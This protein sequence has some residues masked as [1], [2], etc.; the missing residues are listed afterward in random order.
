MLAVYLA[1][2]RGQIEAYDTQA[3]ISVTKNLIDHGSLTVGGGGWPL[4]TP[5][6]PYGIGI[7]VLAIPAYLVSK[8]TGHFPILVSVVAPLLTALCVVLVFRI[9]RCLRW[10][11]S[12][13]VFA[14]VAFGILSMAV[15]YTTELF[16]EPAVTLCVL[17]IILGL[18]RWN[19]GQRWAPLWIGIA[20]AAAVQF[21]SDSIVTVWILL[22]AT[23]LFVP[24]SEI[25]SRRSVPLVL[26]PMALSLVL[27]GSYNE[28]RYKK[29]FIDSYGPGGGF[30]TSIFHGLR[31]YLVSP[32]KSLFV[33][34]PLT[35]VGVVGLVLIVC[36]PSMR[37]RPLGVLCLLAIV[38]RVLFFAKW[39]VW[40]G[41]WVWGPRF[42]LPAVAVLS[43]M[44]IPVLQATEGRRAVGVA[45]RMAVGVLAVFAAFVNVLSVRVPLGNWLGFLSNPHW[46]RVY[47]IHGLETAAAQANAVDFDLTKSPI[48]GYILLLRHHLAVMGPDL[49]TAGHYAGVGYVLLAVGAMALVGAACG[50]RPHRRRHHGPSEGDDV[51]VLAEARTPE[52]DV[53]DPSSS[54]GHITSLEPSLSAMVAHDPFDP[55]DGLSPRSHR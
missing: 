5:Y 47:D 13:C 55:F 49:W 51:A 43:L 38:P 31:G 37:N 27:L 7:S 44:I 1:V 30:S 12:H 23:P 40:D 34:N 26:G 10:K 48:W 39:G 41:G 15:W 33:F 18:L 36:V 4:N 32:G 46:R 52:G 2:M 9:G 22:F 28:L 54:D 50:A 53:A 19:Q 35:L 45:T 11:P 6:S 3:M 8:W 14:A 17:V 24:W 25:R 29:I 20:A 16:S 21:R 42:L